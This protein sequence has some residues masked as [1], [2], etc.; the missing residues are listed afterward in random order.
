MMLYYMQS[1][2]LQ[3]VVDYVRLNYVRWYIFARIYIYIYN[4]YLYKI[5]PIYKVKKKTW[6]FEKL[7][8]PHSLNNISLH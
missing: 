4:I 8:N 3:Q 2:D 6:H 7:W 1:I 5:M